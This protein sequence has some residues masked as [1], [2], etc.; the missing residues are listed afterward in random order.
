MSNVSAEEL[1]NKVLSNI[2]QEKGK[3]EFPIDPFELLKSNNVK[4]ILMNSEKLSGIIINDFDNFTVVGINKNDSLERQRFTAAHEYCHYIKDLKRENG[5]EHNIQCLKDS[6][7]AIEKYANKFAASLLM[8]IEELKKVC[9]F[10]KDENGFVSFENITIIAEYFGVSFSSCV[11]EVA[12]KL[13][14]ISGDTEKSAL[15]E[16][17]KKYGPNK[18]RIELIKDRSDNKMLSNM[19]NSMSYIMTDL[20]HYTGCKFIQNY[21]FYDNK[22]EGIEMDRRDVNFILADLNYNGESSKFY[23]QSEPNICMTLGNLKM[24]KYVIETNEEVSID[25]CKKLH[26]LLYDFVPYKD[27]N[28]KYRD[29]EAMIKSGTIQPIPWYEIPEA[30]QN[31]Q[32]EFEYFIQDIDK[33]SNSEYIEQIAYFI[34][35]FIV[36]HPFQD[37]NGRISRALLNWML[38]KKDMPP[39]YIDDSCRDEY[40]KAL[41]E[42]DTNE[43]YILLIMLIEKRIINTML[44]LHQYLFNDEMIF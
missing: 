17:I 35:K 21:I 1:A 22:I 26:E 13:K 30:I 41:S 4:V 42:I 10:Y 2:R 33:Y 12:Y 7:S 31:I 11:Y 43:N 40:Y 20:R 44:E 29:C 23:K 15:K 37:G 19:I 27:G 8:P 32:K 14:M 18:K 34:Y 36:I 39:I 38:K 5:N 3:I 9:D 28:G 16:R 24:Q 6:N 25:K